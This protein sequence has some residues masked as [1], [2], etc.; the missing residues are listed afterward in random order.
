MQVELSAAHFSPFLLAPDVVPDTEQ[1][2][3]VL[4]CGKALIYTQL[5]GLIHL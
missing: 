1:R 4:N 3:T 2:G 5:E